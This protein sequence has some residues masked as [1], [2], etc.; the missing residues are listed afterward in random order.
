M[1]RINNTTTFP[2]TAPASDD[3]V[4]GTDV[5][6]TTNSADGETVNF[7]I[8]SIA[9][10]AFITG[11]HPYNKVTVG[12][13]NDGLIWD[14]S[15][16]GS[17]ATIASPDFED[18]YEYGF[19][20]EDIY[21]GSSGSIVALNIY[22]EDA[23]TYMGGRTIASSVEDRSGTVSS[24]IF[25]IPFPRLV[26]QT[27]R[28]NWLVDWGQRRTGTEENVATGMS[29]TYSST[30]GAILRVR[31]E[32]YRSDGTTTSTFE[33]GKLYMIRRREFLTG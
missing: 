14:F 23:A 21:L 3:L 5:S 24:G 29:F 33:N 28:I 17:S 22:N 11:W 10:L 15:V 31:F 2:I 7:T 8:G 6:N 26:Q 25:T 12:D 16:D 30:P 19:V 27:F 20:I 4:I 9:D 13:S 32:A 1:A 18:G